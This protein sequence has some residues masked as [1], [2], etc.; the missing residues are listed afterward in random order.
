MLN[1]CWML[2]R[3]KSI[4]HRSPRLRTIWLCMNHIKQSLQHNYMIGIFNVSTPY[5][6]NP[7]LPVMLERFWIFD[8]MHTMNE[9]YAWH[10]YGIP[11]RFWK[12]W[13]CISVVSAG[14]WRHCVWHQCAY[15]SHLM[16]S[17]L[18]MIVWVR[19]LLV[20]LLLCATRWSVCLGG[21]ENATL[22]ICL[23]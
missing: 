15:S 18:L 12:H 4:F 21:D 3:A 10:V 6:D 19:S 2:A 7:I 13:W 1:I 23:L 8:D 14:I 22:W 16:L 5:Y 11:Q 17:M 9:Y 20:A